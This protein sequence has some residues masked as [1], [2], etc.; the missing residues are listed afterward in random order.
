MSNKQAYKDSYILDCKCGYNPVSNYL[1]NMY[2]RDREKTEFKISYTF[3]NGGCG[4]NVYGKSIPEAIE[5]W[6]NGIT[7]EVVY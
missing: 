7:D 5:K 4:R 3:H 1:D 2:Y 6:N